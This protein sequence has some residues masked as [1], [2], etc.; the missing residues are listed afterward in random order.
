MPK[1]KLKFEV[2]VPEVPGATK[3]EVRRYIREAVRSWCYGL[4]PGTAHSDG[5][6]LFG[7][8][9]RTTVKSLPEEGYRLVGPSYARRIATGKPAK[10]RK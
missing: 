1:R 8:F 7:A 6:P 3:A 2:A 10:E 9:D 4:N 5:D